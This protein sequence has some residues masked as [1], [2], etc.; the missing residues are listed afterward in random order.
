MAP[1]RTRS[2][3]TGICFTFVLDCACTCIAT[4]P[5]ATHARGLH[6]DVTQVYVL[7]LLYTIY[8]SCILHK[9]TQIHNLY[10]TETFVFVCTRAYI[11]RFYVY[12]LCVCVCVCVY[13]CVYVCMYSYIHI[14]TYIY[15]YMYIY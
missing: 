5:L 3:R 7:S 9:H 6:L 2:I 10:V 14:H 13:A 11:Y 1:L 4:Q 8:I 15:I 12:T